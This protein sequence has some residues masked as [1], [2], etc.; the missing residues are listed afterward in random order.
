MPRKRYHDHLGDISQETRIPHLHAEFKNGDLELFNYITELAMQHF[1]V[2]LT[3]LIYSSSEVD[4]LARRTVCFLAYEECEVVQIPLLSRVFHTNKGNISRHIAYMRDFRNKRLFGGK[5]RK[6]WA[7][8]QLQNIKECITR[9]KERKKNG[10]EK[11][12][13]KKL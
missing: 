2:D 13:M 5:R 11:E 1:E 3:H 12:K 7:N 8:A 4:L 10:K 9:Y 6:D